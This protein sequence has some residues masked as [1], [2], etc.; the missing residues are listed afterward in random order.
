MLWS[1]LLIC[2]TVLLLIDT[3]LRSCLSVVPNTCEISMRVLLSSFFVTLRETDLE[4]LS[5]SDI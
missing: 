2:H 1:S 3:Y 4:K 5:V